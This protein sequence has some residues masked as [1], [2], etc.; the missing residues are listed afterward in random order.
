MILCFEI[1]AMLMCSDA[2]GVHA[3]GDVNGNHLLCCGAVCID[4]FGFIFLHL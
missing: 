3:Y 4:V 1:E 2:V